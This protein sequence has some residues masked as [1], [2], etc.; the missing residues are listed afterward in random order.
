MEGQVG[1]VARD[2]ESGDVAALTR[3]SGAEV[4]GDLFV[5][6]S[7]FRSLLLGQTLGV[8]WHDWS[9]WLPCDR[10]LA[11][12]CEGTAPLIPL[13]RCTAQRGGWTWRI[14]LQ[15]RTGNGHVFASGFCSEE[16]AERTLRGAIDGA[17]RG[18]PRLLRFQAGRS[19]EHTSELQSLMRI[20]YAVFCLKKKTYKTM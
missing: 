14:P 15:H 9:E 10:A 20:S 2:G 18:E 19:E 11:L 3:E 8:P 7:G 6:G 12:A 5:D 17:A 16:E 1:G 4:A 13:T